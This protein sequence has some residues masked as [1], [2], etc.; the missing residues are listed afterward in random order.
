M[1]DALTAVLENNIPDE[2]H[3]PVRKMNL[4]RP[5]NTSV[6]EEAEVVEWLEKE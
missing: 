6:F 4:N 3:I 5:I 2:A 1:L